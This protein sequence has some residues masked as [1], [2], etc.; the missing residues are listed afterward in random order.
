MKGRRGGILLLAPEPFSALTWQGHS[1]GF[2]ISLW[3]FF[4][5]Q[6]LLWD[7][8]KLR[9][10]LLNPK[11]D[12]SHFMVRALGA[13]RNWQRAL[14]RLA[15]LLLPRWEQLCPVMQQ[16]HSRVL[17]GKRSRR[18]H[19]STWAS[20]PGTMWYPGPGRREGPWGLGSFDRK[21]LCGQHAFDLTALL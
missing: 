8:K 1:N 5:C 3:R 11:E 17:V 7:W 4:F 19:V 13:F 6:M 20:L 21:V 16:E 18:D 12:W 14:P 15:E 9:C 2:Q 10:L